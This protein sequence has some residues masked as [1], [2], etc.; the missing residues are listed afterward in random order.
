MYIK[1]KD[2][3]Q[4]EKGKYGRLIDLLKGSKYANTDYS[5]GI[6][7]IKPGENSPEHSHKEC[8]ELYYIIS[9]TGVIEIENQSKEIKQGD[10]VIIPQKAS[11]LVKNTGNS[12]MEFLVIGFTGQLYDGWSIWI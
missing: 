5:V 10:I 1:N 12:E 9:G 11:H 8:D 4:Y 7:K 2:D 6:R 3:F